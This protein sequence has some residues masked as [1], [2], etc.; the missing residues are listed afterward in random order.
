VRTTQKQGRVLHRIEVKAQV[1][2]VAVLLQS[3]QQQF[4]QAAA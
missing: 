3:H 4:V 1:L 2:T